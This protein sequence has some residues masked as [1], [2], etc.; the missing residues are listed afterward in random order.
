M[1]TYIPLTRKKRKSVADTL[2]EAENEHYLDCPNADLP[3]RSAAL[4]LDL[5]LF[6]LATSGVHQL[7]EALRV[8]LPM[9]LGGVPETTVP[10]ISLWTSYFSWML[11]TAAFYGYFVW[12]VIRFGGS[13]AKLL[14][15]MRV[16]DVHSGG[17]LD[18]HQAVVRET[19]GKVFGLLLL[20]GPVVALFRPDR[21]CLH[22]LVT[23]S[24][25]KKVRGVP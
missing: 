16:V 1:G 4:L 8:L 19:V 15:G 11:K 2:L 10:L 24:T 5:I 3:L 14:L 23:A 18:Y 9:V 22:D 6:S 21:R 13:P 12:S 25:V 7:V 17:R 20:A